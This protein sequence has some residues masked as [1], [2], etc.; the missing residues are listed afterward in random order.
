MT[1]RAR[2]R[3]PDHK[4]ASGFSCGIHPVPQLNLHNKEKASHCYP[5]KGEITNEITQGR[6]GGKKQNFEPLQLQ[7]L[8]C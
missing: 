8:E 3:C 7:L 5:P 4:P 1:H 2:N 6:V